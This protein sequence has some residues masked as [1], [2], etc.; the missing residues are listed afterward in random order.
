MI[1]T[2]ILA[3]G[4]GTGVIWLGGDTCGSDC[5]DSSDGKQCPP[6]CPTCA[7]APSTQTMA[8]THVLVVNPARAVHRVDFVAREQFVSSPDPGEIL[9]VPKQGP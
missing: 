7:C 3:F 5:S 6:D 9:H 1:A 8:A 2:L 4:Q